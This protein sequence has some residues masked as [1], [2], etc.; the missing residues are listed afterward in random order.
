MRGWVP[1][2]ATVGAPTA[3]SVTGFSTDRTFPVP[4]GTPVTWTTT[5][6]GGTGPYTYQFWVYNGTTWTI[7]QSW[8]AA[9]M[10][11][12][13]AAGCGHVHA[14]G[15]GAKCRL[16][17]GYDAWLGAG[18]AAIGV[19]APLSAPS[20]TVAPFSPLVVGG[21]AVITAN[22][23]GGTGPYTYQFWVYNGTG[24]T[25]G[26]SWSAANTF[27]WTPPVAGTYTVQVWVRNAGSVAPYD[28]WSN[29][30]PLAVIP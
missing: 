19:A 21:P 24:W 5:A 6:I 2:R 14:S 22:A 10:F 28:S 29:L 1:A 4:A 18:P 17:G 23:T 26:Q 8:S 30:G 25:I 15:V 11:T 20:I 12:V 13:D 3:L 9:N 27:T 7:G 16:R